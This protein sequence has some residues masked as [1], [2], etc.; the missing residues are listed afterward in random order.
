MLISG[1]FF[2]LFHF[3]CSCYQCRKSCF[4][5]MV[6]SFGFS[7]IRT[8]TCGGSITLVVN[9]EEQGAV[10]GL[11]GATA[12]IGIIFVPV[13]AMALYSYVDCSLYFGP[14]R[15]CFHALF[16]HWFRFSSYEPCFVKIHD[17]LSS[18]SIP[19]QLDRYLSV[20]Y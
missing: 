4:A 6:I 11:I 13:T 16:G 19:L 15:V 20:V 3:V 1:A 2:L 9:P 18:F 17:T 7:L 12:A 14:Y 5:S 8:G 10:A